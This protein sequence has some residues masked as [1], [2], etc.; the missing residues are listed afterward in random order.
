MNDIL[1]GQLARV[2]LRDIWTHEA[3]GFT[4]W[5]ARA[6]NLKVLADALGNSLELEAQERAVGPFRADLLCKEVG[7]GS[8]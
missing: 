1:L 7:T 6:E 5:L 2:D 8:H 4:P 3:T